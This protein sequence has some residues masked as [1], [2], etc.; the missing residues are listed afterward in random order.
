MNQRFVPLFLAQIMSD[1]KFR[2]EFCVFFVDSGIGVWYH[3]EI[4]SHLLLLGVSIK[5]VCI[6]KE[7]GGD[8]IGSKGE[9][10]RRCGE[11]I[12][13]LLLRVRFNRNKLGKIVME[14]FFK[15]KGEI[16]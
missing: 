5:C 13:N 7:E 11:K 14:N 6:C 10:W 2:N 9:S 1:K 16:K 8:F 12:F 4:E 3:T 15:R